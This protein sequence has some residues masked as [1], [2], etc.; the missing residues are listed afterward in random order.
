MNNMNNVN[1][2]PM[3]TL[4]CEKYHESS[5]LKVHP[6][7]VPVDL[8]LEDILSK[9]NAIC[10]HEEWLKRKIEDLEYQVRRLQSDLLAA[11]DRLHFL[12]NP[13]EPILEYPDK[14]KKKEKVKK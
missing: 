14:T 1:T 10:F 5:G 3:L 6:S 11:L 9:I 7:S 13:E 12:E 4:W 8:V 2:Y